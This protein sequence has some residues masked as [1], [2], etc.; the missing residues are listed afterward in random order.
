M[1][2]FENRLVFAVLKSVRRPAR[3][4]YG[5]IRTV[6]RRGTVSLLHESYTTE[7]AAERLATRRQSGAER[8]LRRPE[9]LRKTQVI[10]R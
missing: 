8:C 4:W 3:S 6:T 10:L 7:V 9:P 5:L 1:S 2:A